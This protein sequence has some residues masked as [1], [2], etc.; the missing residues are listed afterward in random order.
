MVQKCEQFLNI[1]KLKQFKPSIW[2]FHAKMNGDRY[3]SKYVQSPS[4]IYN[5]VM[6]YLFIVTRGRWQINEEE[7]KTNSVSFGLVCGL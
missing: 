1:C 4:D 2:L 5:F 7:F 6:T 3:E